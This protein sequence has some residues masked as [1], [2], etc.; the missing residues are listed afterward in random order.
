[1]ELRPL[2]NTGIAVSPIGLGTVKL[3]RDRAVKY[4]DPVTIPDDAQAREL[5]RKALDLGVNLLDTAPAYG[6]SEQRL[7]DLLHTQR[8]R[9]VI[10]TKAG[11]E[12]D[13]E[14]DSGRGESCF[15]FSPEAIRASVHR[16]LER[17]R[18]DRVEA[19]L[20]HSDGRDT[21]IIEHCG[22]LETLADLKR[23]G[24][25]RAVGVSTKTPE[26][27][28]LAAQRCDVVMCTLNP[29]DRAD[30]PAIEQART[31][32]VGVLIKKALLSG[33]LD[34]VRAHAPDELEAARGDAA[35]ACIRY[36]LRTPGVAS[37]IVGTANP[38]H[39]EQNAAAAALALTDPPRR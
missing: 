10:V 1:M 25:V 17:L 12:F 7:G 16:S 21:W 3:G 38:A 19:V 13:P 28:A 8:D 4:P 29:R 36:A 35:Q 5:L 15:D 6:D 31:R 20:L 27:A 22:A 33:H 37:V 24:K 32:G 14:A 26:G 39:L 23:E 30:L 34:Q 2:G 9:W 11:E 18:T